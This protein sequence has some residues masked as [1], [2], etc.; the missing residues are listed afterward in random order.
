[1]ILKTWACAVL[2]ALLSASCLFAQSGLSTG[3]IRGRVTDSSRALIIGSSIEVVNVNTGWTTTT[4]TDATGNYQATSLRPGTYELRAS[5]AGFGGQI[6]TPVPVTV[7]NFRTVDF[8]LKPGPPAPVTINVT[9]SLALAES[10]RS[11]QADT[12]DA[13]TL[14]DLPMDRHDYLSIARLVPGVADSDALA[15]VNDYRVVQAAQSGISFHGN[16]GRGNSIIVDGGE[17]NDSGGGV[18]PT[19]SQDAVEE[20]QVNLSNYSAELGG[21]SGGVISIISKAGA[22]KL[23]G[24]AYG[25]FR[26][27]GLDAADPFARVFVQGTL[28]RIKPPS[29]RQQF[30]ATVGGAIRPDRT[31]YFAAFEGLRR[32]ES[33]SVSVLTDLSIF[34]PT[35]AQ[36]AILAGLPPSQSTALR[37][38][39]TISPATQ[40]LFEVNSGVFPYDGNDYKFSVRLDHQLSSRD[41]FMFRYN[42]ADQDESNPNSRALIGVSRSI[43]TSR[44]DHTGSLSWT[45]FVSSTTVNRLQYQFNYGAF[46]VSTLEKFGPAIDINGYG[47]FNRDVLLPS[48]ILWRRHDVN[49]SLTMV[50]GSH[51]LKLGG[52]LLVR[53]NHVESHA[54]LPGRFVFGTLPGAVADSALTTTTINALQ[55]FNLGLPQFYQQG[56]GDPN[57]FSTEPYFAAYVQDRWQIKTL[58]LDLGLRYELDDLRDPIR[59]DTNNVAPRLGLAWD[60]NGDRKTT[61]RAGYGIFYAPTSYALPAT[62]VPLGEINGFR[63]IAQVFTSIQTAGAANAANM[64]G[65][66]RAQGVI[67]MPTPTRSI[68]EADV[69]PFG[70]TITHDGPRPSNSVLFRSADDFASSYTQQASLGVERTIASDWLVSANYLFVRGAKIMRAR[71]ENLLPAPVSPTLGIPVWSTPFFKDPSLLQGNVYESSGNSFYHGLTLEVSRRLKNHIRFTGNYTLSKAIDEVVD[72]NSDFQAN[73]QLNLRAERGLSSFDQRHKVVAYAFLESPLSPG[74]GTLSNVFGNFMLSPL[75]TISSSRPFN[76]LVGADLNGDKHPTTDRPVSAGRNTGIGPGFWTFDLRLARS[77]PVS[78]RTKIE[79]IGEAFNLFNTLNFKSVNNTVG[80]LP[81]PFR[82]HG[83]A[84]LS[85]SQPFGFTSAF[86]AR[87]FQL[88]VR[89]TF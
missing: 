66:L 33:N 64:Y 18:R 7:G 80:N 15:D 14:R 85:A 87:R 26:A 19:L 2:L 27:S 58:T 34:N 46:R 29:N 42:F 13:G 72:Y 61:V 89:M 76:L 32:R 4:K 69:S 75:V 39:L 12:I 30:G 59:T 48:N 49:D 55:A 62:V 79:V 11:S 20:F 22:N 74:H 88:G 36:E 17:A 52:Q 37:Q 28:Q 23:H 53:D 16:N 9:E 21:A 71:D 45:R 50:R 57:I 40:Q 3:E 47:Y 65:T 10:Q 44:L 81:G 5:A 8:E 56:F 38:K 1:V 41:Q 73:D 6:L 83:D 35:P 24:S 51:Q 77:I 63:Q 68:T 31:F 54:F 25:F 78:D 43:D 70:I 60:V 82:R 84:S 67:T 86:D